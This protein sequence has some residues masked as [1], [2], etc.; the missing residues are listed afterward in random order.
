IKCDAEILILLKGI[1]E[2]FSQMVHTRTSFKPEEIIWNAKFGNIYNKMKSD[3]PISI[4]IQ[5]LSDIEIL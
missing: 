2:G 1:D 4:D 5:K 3:E